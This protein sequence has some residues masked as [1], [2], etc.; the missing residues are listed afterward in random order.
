MP[1]VIN[2]DRVSGGRFAK[3]RHGHHGTR[4]HHDKARTRREANFTNREGVPRG[5]AKLVLVVGEGILCLCN[6]NREFI[7]AERSQAV[8]IASELKKSLIIHQMRF[9]DSDVDEIITKIKE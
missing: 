8:K 3:T 5:S 1:V 9:N 7:K 6:A 2:I 4:Q